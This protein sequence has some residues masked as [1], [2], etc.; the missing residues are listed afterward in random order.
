[1]I[2][3]LGEV[4]SL[5]NT[6]INFTWWILSLFSLLMIHFFEQLAV[7]AIYNLTSCSIRSFYLSLEFYSFFVRFLHLNMIV[8][9]V[10]LNTLDLNPFW[11]GM[12]EGYV[13]RHDLIWTK[14]TF[15]QL[16]QCSDLIS[17]NRKWFRVV[18][19][20][21]TTN[22]KNNTHPL[23]DTE[24]MNLVPTKVEKTIFSGVSPSKG[25]NPLYIN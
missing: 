19:R 13:P 14:K 23:N 6:N 22:S 21:M 4:G 24:R 7:W 9:C 11:G 5:A 2:M 1:M 15:L 25:F 20:D 18:V 10:F 8:A 3:P 17:F 16:E 12:R